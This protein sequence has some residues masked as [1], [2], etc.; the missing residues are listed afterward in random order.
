MKPKYKVHLCSKCIKD[1]DDYYPYLMSREQLE[2]IEVS[3]EECD[4]SYLETYNERLAARNPEWTEANA[5]ETLCS[6]I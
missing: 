6:D 3:A 4:N 5:N 1:L 2:I